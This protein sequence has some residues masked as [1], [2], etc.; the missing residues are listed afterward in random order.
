M[1]SP[2]SA[3]SSNAPSPIWATPRS[4]FPASPRRCR[5][6]PPRPSTSSSLSSGCP[7]RD[8]PFVTVNC[9]ALPEG[10]VES[11]LFGH[12]RGAFTGAVA[13]ASGAFERAHHGTLLLDEIS[14]MRLDLQAKLL[15]AIQE[16]EIE[17]VGSHQPFKVHVRVV[18]TTNRDLKAEVDAGRFRSDLY[19]RLHVFPIR[20]PALRERAEDI[21]L[22]VSHFVKQVAG[23]L[24]IRP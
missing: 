4:W 10:L 19:W 13:R 11:S 7:R 15:R 3:C 1:S 22:L 18:A 23:H 6:C 21:P 14:E 2:P 24:G 8:Q 12:E 16:Q 20:T 17:R 9:A 5:P